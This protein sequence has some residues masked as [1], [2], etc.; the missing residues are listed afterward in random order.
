MSRHQ[1]RHDVDL[2]GCLMLGSGVSSSGQVYCQ[3]IVLGVAIFSSGPLGL[4]HQYHWFGASSMLL[5][6]LCLA[7]RSIRGQS[8]QVQ[9]MGLLLQICLISQSEHLGQSWFQHGLASPGGGALGQDMGTVLADALQV[10]RSSA[11]S[12]GFSGQ[13]C[14]WLP[15][16]HFWADCWWHQSLHQGS[17]IWL[18][19]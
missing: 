5:G 6:I 9:V 11:Q 12:S 10:N 8:L 1:H 14:T 15:D 7:S 16:Y 4:R 3:G 2:D 19:V 13:W 18:F 17:F